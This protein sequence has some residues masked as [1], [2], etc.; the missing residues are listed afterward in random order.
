MLEG[1][2]ALVAGLLLLFFG[3]KLF[4]LAA[5]LVAFLFSGRLLLS[6][7]EPNTL[8][9]I[10]SIL[11]GVVFAWLAIRFIRLAAYIIGFLAGAVS[12]YFLADLFSLEFNFLLLFLIGGVVGVVLILAAFDWGLILL[13]AWV[14][15]SAVMVGLRNWLNFEDTLF[16]TIL[17]IALMIVGIGWQASRRRT[18]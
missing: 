7:F 6:F 8:I 2:L 3:R 12:F 1:I 9:L 4:W 18:G 17:L 10:V 5:A 13:T 11:T 14:G 16:G 15:A